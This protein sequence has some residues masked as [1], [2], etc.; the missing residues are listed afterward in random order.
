MFLL[1]DSVI[2]TGM[3]YRRVQ[4]SFDKEGNLNSCTNKAVTCYASQN[5]MIYNAV[6]SSSTWN[7]KAG[8]S[9]TLRGLRITV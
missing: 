1:A 8:L 2:C 6:L 7:L 9:S 4:V 5:A 3:F